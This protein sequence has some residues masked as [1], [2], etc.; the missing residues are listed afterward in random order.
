[1][2]NNLLKD[3]S[4]LLRVIKDGHTYEWSSKVDEPNGITF[5]I[6]EDDSAPNTTGTISLSGVYWK[7]IDDMVNIKTSITIFDVALF[8]GYQ[9]NYNAIFQ[10]H[11]VDCNRDWQDKN[12]VIFNLMGAD[13]NNNYITINA[14]E[15]ETNLSLKKKFAKALG[16]NLDTNLLS[17]SNIIGEKYT[18]FGRN[19]VA[20]LKRLFPT[21]NVTI[22]SKTLFFD[23]KYNS[24]EKEITSIR[25]VVTI[26]D[27]LLSNIFI[28]GAYGQYKGVFPLIPQLTIGSYVNFIQNDPLN[29]KFN[30]TYYVR[31]VNHSGFFEPRVR[32]DGTTT[33]VLQNMTLI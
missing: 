30:G 21:Q 10:G 12:K 26:K 32:V 24:K 25:E 31:Y 28:E 2:T 4:Y 22:K 15:N 20:E 23:K 8:V 5:D 7:D 16:L 14:S 19:S 3:Y 27:K 33:I 17:D 18:F 6:T 1:M 9:G 13:I 11:C 29:K